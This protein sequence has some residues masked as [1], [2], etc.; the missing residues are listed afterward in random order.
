MSDYIKRE[1]ARKALCGTCV[2]KGNCNE[3]QDFKCNTILQLE[4]IPPEDVRPVEHGEWERK[5]YSPY[6]KCS[7]CG[8]AFDYADGLLYLVAGSRLPHFCPNCG[9]DMRTEGSGT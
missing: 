2:V 6:V 4:V 1:D 7:H 8:M 3:G 9:A 5:E